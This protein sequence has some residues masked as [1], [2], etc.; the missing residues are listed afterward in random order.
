MLGKTETETETDT[1][2]EIE[3]ERDRYVE[4]ERQC[5]RVGCSSHREEYLMVCPRHINGWNV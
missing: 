5:V 4:R 2:I 1:E 3:R